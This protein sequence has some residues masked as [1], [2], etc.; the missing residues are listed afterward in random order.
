MPPGWFHLSSGDALRPA[1]SRS[2]RPG[3]HEARPADRARDP[4]V[5]VAGKFV[6]LMKNGLLHHAVASPQAFTD[7]ISH[8]DYRPHDYR[9]RLKNGTGQDAF[10]VNR[11]RDDYHCYQ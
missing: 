6:S 1:D 3:G 11:A 7:L 8:Y 5:A 10:L 4:D 2:R 9:P